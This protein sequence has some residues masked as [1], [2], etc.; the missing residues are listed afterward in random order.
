VSRARYTVSLTITDDV[1]LARTE[2][3]VHVSVPS[4]FGYDED[5]AIAAVRAAVRKVVARS[6]TLR[7]PQCDGHVFDAI[8]GATVAAGVWSSEAR[9]VGKARESAMVP[10]GAVVATVKAGWS[11]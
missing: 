8:R 1:T 4:S 7:T 5:E 3:V 6:A 2:K 9:G 10:R 11:R